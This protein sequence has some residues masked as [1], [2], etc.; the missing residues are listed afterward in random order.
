MEKKSSVQ[1][2][3]RGPSF[4]LTS[5]PFLGTLPFRYTERQEMTFDMTLAEKSTGV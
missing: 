2:F 4:I 3:G 5:E 1:L